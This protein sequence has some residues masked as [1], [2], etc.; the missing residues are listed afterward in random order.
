M[1]E[2]DINLTPWYF[3]RH[4]PVLK[5]KNGLY[6]D[7]DV[8]AKLPS[9][10]AINSMAA[11][12]PKNAQWFISP[13]KRTKTT[14][15]ALMKTLNEIQEFS[16]KNEILE[17]DF[18]QWQGLEFDALWDNI[19]NL[20]AH[21]W[22]LL[23]AKTSPPEG[24]SFSDVKKRVASFIESTTN[25]SPVKPKIVVTH[26]GVIRSAIGYALELEDD[27]AL[28]IEIEPFSLT[29]LLHQN[30]S[31]RGGNWQLKSS[32]WTFI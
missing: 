15:N 11:H 28:S 20:E 22:S 18:G 19:K 10:K 30:G 5:S 21:N 7:Q 9:I 29:R 27:H 24:E 6:K 17:Q 1:K 26:A 23:S 31:G 8:D 2:H 12:L 13:M 32:N 25:K 3:I 14:A 4:A 16:V